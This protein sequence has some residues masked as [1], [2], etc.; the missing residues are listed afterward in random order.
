[1]P[2]ADG[3]LSAP[4]QGP[5]RS[6]LDRLRDS[7]QA[8]PWPFKVLIVVAAPITVLAMLAFAPYAVWTSRRGGWA[9]ASAAM[10]GIVLVATQ[11]HGQP[12]PHYALLALPVIAA[13]AAHAGAL[14]RRYVPCR[15]VAWVL[16]L[17]LL[18]GIAA[19]R[20]VGNGH[21][22]IGPALAWLL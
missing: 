15:T 3:S 13:L 11:A 21:S 4:G 12:L 8:A 18:P 9:T 17:A 6:A 10:W 20:V 19:F 2:P 14:G 16:L 22:L 5:V 7:Y 1:M